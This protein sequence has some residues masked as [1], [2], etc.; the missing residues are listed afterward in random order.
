MTIANTA[1]AA[2]GRNHSDRV[3]VLVFFHIHF[4]FLS[5]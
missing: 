1:A 2:P 3:K 5:L 4:E